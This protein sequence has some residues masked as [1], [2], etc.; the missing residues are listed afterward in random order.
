MKTYWGSGGIVTL[1]LDLDTRWRWTVSFTPGRFTPRERVPG[2]QWIGGKPHSCNDIYSSPDVRRY[3]SRYR[4]F[5]RLKYNAY[6]NMFRFTD[7]R[8]DNGT[9]TTT[10]TTTIIII[11]II[12][13]IIMF[14]H[15]SVNVLRCKARP[16]LADGGDD[17]QILRVAD[18][19]RGCTQKFPDWIDNEIYAYNNKHSV[20]KQHKRLWRQN[21][22]D[23]LTK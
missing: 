7:P 15:W 5:F 12:I 13:I 8:C 2:T 19:I 14:Q 17:L 1:I 4:H 18:N 6:T 21:S 16:R 11:I 10:T 22:L 9:T 3:S 23:W 20:E